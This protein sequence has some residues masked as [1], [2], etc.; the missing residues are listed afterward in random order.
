MIVMNLDQIIRAVQGA[1][2]VNSEGSR[3][4][5]RGNRFLLLIVKCDVLELLPFRVVPPTVPVRLLPSA[6]T[7]V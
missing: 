3:P 6:E 5:K 1:L 2:G 7:T 4:P